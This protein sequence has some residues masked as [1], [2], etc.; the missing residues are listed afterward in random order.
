M[1]RVTYGIASSA[2]HSIR[3]LQVLAE[4][5]T[6]DHLPLSMTTDMHVDDL[7]VPQT[8]KQEKNCGMHLSK[9]ATAD[10]D[11]RKWASSD[12]RLVSKL[13]GFEQP[14][15]QIVFPVIVDR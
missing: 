8:F 5:T 9:L 3:P 13:A 10:F 1:T 6:I 14:P 4:E 11:I 12:S 15:T 7:Q 2:Y